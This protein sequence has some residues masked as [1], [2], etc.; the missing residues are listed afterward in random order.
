[1]IAGTASNQL[2]GEVTLLDERSSFRWRT[3]V[4]TPRAV[5][6]LSVEH[7]TLELY[8]YCDIIVPL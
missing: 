8:I 1:M 7:D 6:M 3:T 2:V 5:L 4:V